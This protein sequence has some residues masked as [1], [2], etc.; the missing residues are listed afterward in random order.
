[1]SA[2]EACDIASSYVGIIERGTKKASIDTLVRISNALNVSVDYLLFDSLE[3]ADDRLTHINGDILTVNTSPVN[4]NVNMSELLVLLN[5]IIV[6]MSSEDKEFEIS[7]VL[8]I[9]EN[10]TEYYRESR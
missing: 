5:K 10:I 7:L 3:I 9:L 4:R 2:F 6:Q 1:M 8:K